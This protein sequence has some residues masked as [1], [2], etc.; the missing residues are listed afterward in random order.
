VIH[1]A[2]AAQVYMYGGYAIEYC[3]LDQINMLHTIPEQFYLDHINF[4]TS[5]YILE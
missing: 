5:A 1:S 2:V 4:A 3:Q